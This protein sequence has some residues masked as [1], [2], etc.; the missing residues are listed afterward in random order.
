[1]TQSRQDPPIEQ[2][3]A[4]ALGALEPAEVHAFEAALA[5][6]PEL[7]RE[8]AEYREL[9]AVLASAEPDQPPA[10][11]KQ[12]LLDRVRASRTPDR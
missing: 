1:M 9:C 2:V 8:L 4:Y 7:Q 5:R 6:S 12:R 10:A 11:L 3:A